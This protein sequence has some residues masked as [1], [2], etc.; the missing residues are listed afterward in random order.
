MFF[1]YDLKGENCFL[2]LIEKKMYTKDSTNSTGNLIKSTK[3]NHFLVKFGLNFEHGMRLSTERPKTEMTQPSC[4]R[5]GI[6]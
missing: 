5:H 6:L 2:G 3:F 1:Y 4:I